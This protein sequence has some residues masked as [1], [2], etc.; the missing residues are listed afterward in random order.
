M[1]KITCLL[2][3]GALLLLALSACTPATTLPPASTVTASPTPTPSPSPTPTPLALP[4]VNSAS[5]TFLGVT[6][7]AT[8]SVTVS[9]TN[10]AGTFA[11][12]TKNCGSTASISGTN[13]FTVTPLGAGACQY[14]FTDSS[15]QSATLNI[16]VTVTTGGGN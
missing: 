11:A 4:V 12:T 14:T 7:T 10:Y 2:L 16:S 9:E 13:P 8:Q 6:N 3:P 15:S 5:L 1:L